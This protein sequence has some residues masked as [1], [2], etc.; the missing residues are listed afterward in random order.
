MY[1]I[2]LFVFLC[3]VIIL[4]I[5]NYYTRHEP[6]NEPSL[7]LCFS[8]CLYPEKSYYSFYCKPTNAKMATSLMNLWIICLSSQQ[9][10]TQV[11][12]L[13]WQ[14]HHIH[15]E[16]NNQTSRR[17]RREWKSCLAKNDGEK[18]ITCIVD[19]RAIEN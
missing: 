5:H 10:K 16:R 12:S 13:K 1:I 11:K 15:R 17:R 6:P 7:L 4:A 2:I 14:G 8:A 9:T 3:L 19:T 18:E